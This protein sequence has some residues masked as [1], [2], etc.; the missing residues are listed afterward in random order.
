MNTIRRQ[1]SIGELARSRKQMLAEVSDRHYDAAMAASV[2][3]SNLF[4][5][6]RG[7]AMSTEVLKLVEELLTE[8][9]AYIEA[10]LRIQ[11]EL[12]GMG[13]F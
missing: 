4:K 2:K 6:Y 9:S 8:Q 1:V 12:D 5:L 13:I 11:Q 3:V 10:R 7:K